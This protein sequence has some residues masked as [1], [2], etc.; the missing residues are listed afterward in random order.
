MAEEIHYLSFDPEKI[1]EEMHRAYLEAGGEALYPGDEKDM[2]LRSC[3][4]VITQA[5]AGVDHALRMATLRYATGEYLD[6]YGENRGCLRMEALAAEAE[7]E[8]TAR[9]TGKPQLLKSGTLLTADGE[10]L[11]ALTDSVML[12]GLAQTLR[13]VIR[14]EKTGTDGNA[15]TAGTQMQTL[16]PFAG[17]EGICCAESAAGGRE[18]E[19]DESYRER[20]RAYGLSNITTGPRQQYEAAAMAVSTEILDARAVNQGAGKVG[21]AILA[22]EGAE[23]S[24]LTEVETVLNDMS[25]RPLTD[26]VNVFRAEEKPY[27]IKA[28]Y[29]ADRG[30]NLAEDMAE[31]VKSY[32]S[33]QDGTIG[34]AFNPDRLMAAMYQAGAERVAWQTG[35]AFGE[36]GAIEYTEIPETACCKGT[37]TLEV[38]N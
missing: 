5:F 19:D 8:I 22:A 3:Q 9:A 24:L 20:I 7:I 32:Q 26:Q 15:L 38:L 23:D 6:L 12:S 31:C 14:A 13:A 34:R 36:A 16:L 29:K 33:W 21:I 35:S 10:T 18:Q 4:A 30:E 11:Y 2:L 28:A 17:I 25:V 1:F 27:T 37:I